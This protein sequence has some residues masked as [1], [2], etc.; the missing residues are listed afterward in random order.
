MG[1]SDFSCNRCND[2]FKPGENVPVILLS[3]PENSRAFGTFDRYV[4]ERRGR[5]WNYRDRHGIPVRRSRVDYLYSKF[6]T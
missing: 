1:N 3:R 2:S 5:C 4:H 6:G